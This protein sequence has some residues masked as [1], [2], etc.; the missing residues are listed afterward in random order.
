MKA[1]TEKR[2]MVLTAAIRTIS[3]ALRHLYEDDIEAAKEAGD[4]LQVVRLKVQLKK[5]WEAW[6]APLVAA[7]EELGKP[8]LIVAPAGDPLID[9]D[10]AAPTEPFLGLKGCPPRLAVEKRRK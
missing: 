9:G 4:I 7:L 10:P 3:T 5:D 2:R 8:S 6:S 1:D